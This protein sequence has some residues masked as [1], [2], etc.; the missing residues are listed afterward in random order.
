MLFLRK[1]IGPREEA[2][3]SNATNASRGNAAIA[4]IV[5]NTSE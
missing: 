5:L 4:T 3:M 2:R 1:K